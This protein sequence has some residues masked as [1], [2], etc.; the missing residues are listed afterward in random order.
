MNKGNH[1]SSRTTAA[2]IVQA[3]IQAYR[4]KGLGPLKAVTVHSTS[5]VSTSWVALWNVAADVI[6]KAALWSSINTF[7]AHYCVE[8]ASYHQSILI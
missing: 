2:W 4:A 8:P 5:S 1:A 6:C 3:N 7:M